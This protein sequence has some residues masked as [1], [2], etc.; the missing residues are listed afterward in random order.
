MYKETA[1]PI[2]C[3]GMYYIGGGGDISCRQPE[4]DLAE[5]S[6]YRHTPAEC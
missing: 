2:M 3:E 6:V 5:H 1:M 4:E